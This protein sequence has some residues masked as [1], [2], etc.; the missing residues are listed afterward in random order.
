MKAELIASFFAEQGKR[1]TNL[2]KVDVSKLDELILKH[3]IDIEEQLQKR[4]IKNEID[5]KAQIEMKNDILERDRLYT[6]ELRA[7][8]EAHLKSWNSITKSQQMFI[9]EKLANRKN[10]EVRKDYES[11]VSSTNRFEK[12]AIAAGKRVVRLSPISLRVDFVDIHIGYETV[13]TTAEQWFENMKTQIS[14]YWELVCDDIHFAQL[15]LADL[16]P[17]QI[18]RIERIRAARK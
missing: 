11:N 7:K 14:S 13:D 10:E 12:T 6:E 18:A 2:K 16:T 8:K 5:K 3:N 1:L 4:A 15:S 9:C 17:K